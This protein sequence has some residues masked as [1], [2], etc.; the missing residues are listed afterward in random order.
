MKDELHR[1]ILQ[2][3]LRRPSQ[4][5]LLVTWLRAQPCYPSMPSRFALQQKIEELI[6][7]KL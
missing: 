2:V 1:R 3:L 7:E 5:T 4:F 6:G